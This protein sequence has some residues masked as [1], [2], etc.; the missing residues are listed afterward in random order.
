M[1][2]TIHYREWQSRVIDNALLSSRRDSGTADD[3]AVESR[4]R[5][6]LGF[7]STQG[8]LLTISKPNPYPKS[9]KPPAQKWFSK[10]N[11]W[12]PFGRF[13]G[14][15]RQRYRFVSWPLHDARLF[16]RGVCTTQYY[17]WHSTPPSLYPPPLYFAINIA[18][19]MAFPRPPLFYHSTYNGGNENFVQRPIS[20]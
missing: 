12:N 20:N 11:L 19:C 3:I 7:G 18:Q 17:P 2:Y 13:D 5:P 6:K 8:E 9:K 10:L 1:P 15:E 14:V 4:I 16:I